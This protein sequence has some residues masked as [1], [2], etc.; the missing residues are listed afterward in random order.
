M[1]VNKSIECKMM[2]KEIY[3]YTFYHFIIL[4]YNILVYTE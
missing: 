2:E 3:I 1:E 4:R